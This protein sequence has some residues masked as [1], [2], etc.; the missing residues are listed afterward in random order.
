MNLKD[1]VILVTG[2]SAGIGL[3]TAKMLKEKG[4]KVIIT[5]RNEDRLNSA[6]KENDFRG[7][8]S[9]VSKEEDIV[10]LFG[11]I[12]NEFGTI[13]VLINNAGFGYFDLLENVNAEKFSD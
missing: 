2:G 1:K 13:D 3:S 9:D 5:G 8:V 4:A 10:K 11:D 6:A 12:K 7:Y